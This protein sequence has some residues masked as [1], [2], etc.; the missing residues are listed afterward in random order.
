MAGGGLQKVVQNNIFR[1]RFER[2]LMVVVN[3]GQDIG[4]VVIGEREDLGEEFVEEA[5]L[6]QIECDAADMVVGDDVGV[7]GLLSE[8]VEE[9]QR[10]G[11][12]SRGAFVVEGH[13]IGARD[14]KRVV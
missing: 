6:L 2:R 5:L 7:E 14:S 8:E 12:R 3:L 1:S 13:A 9:L 11:E 4:I 10:G